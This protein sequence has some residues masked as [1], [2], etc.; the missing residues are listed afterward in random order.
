MK[1]M[2]WITLLLLSQLHVGAQDAAMDPKELY[3]T[4]KGFVRS[5]DYS[6]AILV[7]NQALQLDPGNLEYQKEL[8][9]SYYYRRDIDKAQAVIKPILESK[10]ADVQAYQIAGNILQATQD[11]KGAEK[12]YNKGLRKFPTSGELYNELGL[13]QFSQRN[14]EAAL[15]SWI[16][17]IEVDPIFPTNYYHAART[18]FY[19]TNKVW[20]IIYGEI[21]IN[22]ESYTTRTAEIKGIL[23]E[24]YKKL[25]DD[26][27]SLQTTLPERSAGKKKWKKQNND[28]IPSFANAYL[29]NLA[30]ESSVITSGITPE[31]LVMLR[32]RFILDW[33]NVYNAYYPF[34]LFEFQRKLLKEGLFDAYNQWIFG[35]VSSQADYRNWTQNHPTTFDAFVRFQRNNP[36]KPKG[37]EYY[38]KEKI[39][40]EQ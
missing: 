29:A 6:N 12:L 27:A 5:G 30:R 23:L 17:G 9:L 24:S 1:Q 7:L 16:K 31:S 11:L 18:Y 38:N 2:P 19:T 39:V 20:A 33:Y 15:K 35:P 13:L 34:S 21:F 8:A 32:T 40:F 37:G 25:F 36:Y 26:P 28:G 4:A 14:Y 3:K 10:R 22:L